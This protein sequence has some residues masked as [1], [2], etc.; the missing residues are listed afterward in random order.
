LKYSNQVKNYHLFF[1]EK[2]QNQKLL[3]E[4]KQRLV[5]RGPVTRW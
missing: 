5:G 4:E 3:R 2:L 1:L